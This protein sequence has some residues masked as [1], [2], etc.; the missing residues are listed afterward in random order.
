MVALALVASACGGGGSNPLGN[1]P[2]VANPAGAT[3]QK[4][5]FVY[6]QK[7][8]NPIFL[9][10]LPIDQ[11]GVISTN[12]CAGSGCHANATGTGGA[13]RVVPTAPA[14]DLSDPAN[15]PDAIR[16]SDMYKNFYSAQGEV[17]LGSATESRLLAKPLLLNVLHGGGQI[18]ANDQDPNARLI[19]YWITHPVPVGQDEF[20]AAAA[21][22]FTPADP[23]TGA[24]N[25]Q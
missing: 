13:F 14:V 19:R 16:A 6:F 5:S 18:F 3:G 15:T 23:A 12:T 1:P 17:V 8:I 11:N 22:M 20:S 24:C 10:Q 9:A 7:C 21:T 25:T 4:L 2:T